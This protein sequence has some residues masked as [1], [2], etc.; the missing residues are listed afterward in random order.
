MAKAAD[1]RAQSRHS[2]TQPALGFSSMKRRRIAVGLGPRGGELG[3]DAATHLRSAA[4]ETATVAVV[5]FDHRHLL[6][7]QTLGAAPVQRRSEERRV[8]KECVST[9]RS[10]WAPYPEKKKKHENHN[11][12]N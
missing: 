9:C 8:G 4:G 3:L 12:N 10:G 5:P 6:G 2:N 11:N 1:R 7:I